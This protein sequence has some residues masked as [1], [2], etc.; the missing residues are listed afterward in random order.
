MY[1]HFKSVFVFILTERATDGTQPSENWAL[2]MEVCDVINETDDGLVVLVVL[3][4]CR[5]V[6]C[7]LPYLS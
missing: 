1:F 3:T 5:S 4:L 2:F 7:T 6:P